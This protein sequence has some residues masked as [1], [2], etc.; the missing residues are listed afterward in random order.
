MT[1]QGAEMAT[2]PRPIRLAIVSDHAIFRDALR[3]LLS[4]VSEMSVVDREADVI[5]L[6]LG[7]SPHADR[8]V[9]AALSSTHPRARIVA[10][11]PDLDDIAVLEL[12]RRGAY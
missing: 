11:T 1:V 10:L 2:A 7:T 9:L 4:N 6:D 3:L 12:L 5:L 8:Q